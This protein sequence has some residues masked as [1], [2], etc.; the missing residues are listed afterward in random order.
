MVYARMKESGRRLSPLE[1]IPDD[2]PEMSF[3]IR[4]LRL[5]DRGL[6]WGRGAQTVCMCCTAWGTGT[7][8]WRRAMVPPADVPDTPAGALD[9]YGRSSCPCGECR[10]GVVPGD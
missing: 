6:R 5:V 3:K 9:R 1:T 4:I 2:D 7:A 10:W 8:V